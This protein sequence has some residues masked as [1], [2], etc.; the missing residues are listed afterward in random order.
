M[1]TEAD[2][3]GLKRNEAKR[4]KKNRM[5]PSIYN[6]KTQKWNKSAGKKSLTIKRR[7]YYYFDNIT[8]KN[9]WRVIEHLVHNDQLL[10]PYDGYKM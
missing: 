8:V 6:E 5:K 3:S 1:R 10:V 4:L 9:K 2:W 7:S